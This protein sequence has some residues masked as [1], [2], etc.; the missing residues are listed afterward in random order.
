M[1]LYDTSRDDLKTI[2]AALGETSGSVDHSEIDL[3]VGEI[4]KRVR[5]E[6]DAAVLEYTRRFDWQAVTLESLEVSREELEQ[7]RR[8]VSAASLDAL[9]Q[10]A[11]NI[12]E[13]H[14]REYGQMQS[15]MHFSQN[16]SGPML[17]QIVRPVRS[18]GVYVPGGHAAY[19]STVLMAAVPAR[20]AGVDE[21]VICTP[22][23][24]HGH[25]P[26]LVAAA[27][28]GWADRVF[29][30]G[31][32]Q[33]IPAMA[34][35]TKTIP[36][37]DVVVGPGNRFVNAAKRLVYGTVG[38]DMLAGP[39]EVCVI[40]DKGANPRFA[41]ADMLA[42]TEHG[43]DNRGILLCDDQRVI[44]NILSEIDNMRFDLMRK[45]II[46]ETYEN[47]I[48]VKTRTIDEAVELSN[49]LA[50]EHLE[51]QVR[52]PMALLP[53]IRNAGA[54]LLGDYSGAALGDYVA[55]PSHTLPTAGGARFSSPLS[56]STFL[57]RSSVISYSREA[58]VASGE[59]A[60]VIADGEGFDGHALS[61]R[62]RK[63]GST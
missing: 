51:L 54:I 45:S 13:F 23:D 26:P 60:G 58:A 28:Y 50:P 24:R 17:G 62:I 35:G 21:V 8:S 53:K 16:G 47:G 15:W 36:Q 37:V 2:H 41:A 9:E 57:K 56:A 55:G 48:V 42:Q 61:A 27:A 31:G 11:L 34:Y 10:A 7:A 38:I 6:G 25:I 40:A 20:V 43:P 63:E 33:A 59:A 3:T 18:A 14:Q 44:E 4:L 46:D 49:F 19:P 1:R 29:R 22:P 32:A 12:Q 5:A 39:S 52:D 30:I